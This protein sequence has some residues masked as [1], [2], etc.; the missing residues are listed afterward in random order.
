MPFESGHQLQ[1]FSCPNL[2]FN[3]IDLNLSC[4]VNEDI[5]I[6]KLEIASSIKLTNCWAFMC[7]LNR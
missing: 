1:V 6:G 3:F 2:D 5:G 7:S 4:V